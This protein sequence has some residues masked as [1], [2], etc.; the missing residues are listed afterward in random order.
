MLKLVLGCRGE[1]KPFQQA[2][3]HARARLPEL[4][5]DSIDLAGV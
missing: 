4:L 1:Q 3:I 2:E 5:R